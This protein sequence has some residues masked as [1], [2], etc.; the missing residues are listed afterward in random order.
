MDKT[1]YTILGIV[2]IVAVV[3][4]VTVLP[5]PQ[6]E[7]LDDDAITGNVVASQERATDCAACQGK[8]VCATKGTT[9]YNYASACG[10]ECDSA[11]IIYDDVCERIPVAQKR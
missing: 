2:L 3:G 4:L 5:A 6:F 7:P 8:P 11:R 9:A 10:A 1:T